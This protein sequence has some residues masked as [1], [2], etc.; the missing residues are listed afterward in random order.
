MFFAGDKGI[1]VCIEAIKECGWST[2]FITGDFSIAIGVVAGEDLVEGGEFSIAG[3]GSCSGGIG[4]AVR[5]SGSG[6]DGFLFAFEVE[7]EKC[8]NHRKY[9]G[10]CE[11]LA[12]GGT[13][14]GVEMHAAIG[15]FEGVVEEHALL[16]WYDGVF[17]AV[18][19]EKGRIV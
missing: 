17:V 1:L 12:V 16:K 13:L 18:D 15:G 8:L 14:D 11:S 2:K 6:C 5:G 3:I 7:V 10:A 9:L 19:D 4:F